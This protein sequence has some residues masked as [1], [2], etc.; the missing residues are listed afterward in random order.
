MKSEGWSGAVAKGTLEAR[1]AVRDDPHRAVQAEATRVPPDPP[2]A[3]ARHVGGVGLGEKL[4]TDLEPQTPTL[5]E[6][7]EG[8][9]ALRLQPNGG[10][11]PQTRSS[12][13]VPAGPRF[14]A[15]LTLARREFGVG[16]GRWAP[17]TMVGGP[18]QLL[19]EP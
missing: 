13:C 17:P 14:H 2:T 19:A 18:P 1:P 8:P 9:C 15:D 11:K 10:T 7:R 5:D 16:A 6:R 12:D 4:T 3:G